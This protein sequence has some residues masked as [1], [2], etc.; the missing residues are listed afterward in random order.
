[1]GVALEISMVG[2]V[3]Y[4]IYNKPTRKN[5]STDVIKATSSTVDIHIPFE[6]WVLVYHWVQVEMQYLTMDTRLSW[7]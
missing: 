2:K 3:P 5:H 1:M 4:D 7:A 6:K